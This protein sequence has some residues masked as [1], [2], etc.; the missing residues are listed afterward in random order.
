M[1]TRKRIQ[2]PSF[3][4]RMGAFLVVKRSLELDG[5]KHRYGFRPITIYR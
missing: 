2:L 1:V 3:M 4:K 5:T